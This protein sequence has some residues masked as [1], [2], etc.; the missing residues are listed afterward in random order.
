MSGCHIPN[1]LSTCCN[2]LLKRIEELASKVHVAEE[3]ISAQTNAL[4]E[5]WKRMVNQEAQ[6]NQIQD[7]DFDERIHDLEKIEAEP[8]LIRMEEWLGWNRAKAVCITCQGYGKVAREDDGES[9]QGEAD[10]WMV[11]ECPSCEGK[12]VV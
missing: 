2:D 4:L 10:R 5:Y 8:R 1:C 7:N 12:K 9:S 3:K 11:V 6:I